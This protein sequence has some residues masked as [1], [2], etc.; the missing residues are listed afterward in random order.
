MVSDIK[1]RVVTSIC[2]HT[3]LKTMEDDQLTM[4][5]NHGE[6]RKQTRCRH[7]LITIEIRDGIFKLLRSPGIDGESIP[8]AYV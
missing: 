7:C 2:L 6:S 5:D 8:P 1:L 4:S 3:R